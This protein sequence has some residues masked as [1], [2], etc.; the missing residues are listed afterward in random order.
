MNK[1]L[2]LLFLLVHGFCL[3]VF[4][5]PTDTIRI[6]LPHFCDSIE[7]F[8]TTYYQDTVAMHWVT[9]EVGERDT[10]YIVNIHL[11]NTVYVEYYD[12]ACVR[13]FWRGLEITES[14]DYFNRFQYAAENGCDSVEVLHLLLRPMPEMSAIQGDTLVCQHQYAVFN[15]PVSNTEQYRYEWYFQDSLVAV[16]R[17]RVELFCVTD[18][19]AAGTLG[20]CRMVIK[21]N[22]T[23]CASDTSVEVRV[24]QYTSPERP[25]VVRKDN[26]NVLV[27][28]PE[29]VSPNDHYR[30]GYTEK[31]TAFEMVFDWDFNYFQYDSPINTDLYDYWVEVYRPYGEVSCLNRS[32]LDNGTPTF[33]PIYETFSAMAY[34]HGNQLQIRIENPEQLPVQAVLR[35][36]SG[37]T[38]AQFSLGDNPSL[39]QTLPFRYSSGLYLLSFYAGNQCFTSKI[40]R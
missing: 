15:Y 31:Q 11:G 8:G 29:G 7:C 17:S 10:V 25:Q 37:K 3:A 20:N 6:T 16:N 32:Y 18:D 19:A 30:W 2:L 22:L 27:C 21:D 28:S 5:N 26:S 23:E 39:T 24:L 36:V 33:T 13:Y 1:K 9:H 4:S 35:D 38:L 40:V 14:G 12:T 34:V